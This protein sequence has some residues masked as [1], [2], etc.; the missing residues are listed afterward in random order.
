MLFSEKLNDTV[1]LRLKKL[2]GPNPFEIVN[3]KEFRLPINEANVIQE[4]QDVDE[5]KAG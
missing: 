4:V 2:Q 3:G 5:G 1:K